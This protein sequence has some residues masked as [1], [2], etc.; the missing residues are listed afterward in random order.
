MKWPVRSIGDHLRS[1]NSYPKMRKIRAVLDIHQDIIGH[2]VPVR[3][4]ILP[5]HSDHGAFEDHRKEDVTSKVLDPSFT[6][7]NQKSDN[8]K[9]SMLIRYFLVAEHPI[10]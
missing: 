4:Q 3:F 10:K 8:N 2:D 1:Q 5:D 9:K 6:N 7:L